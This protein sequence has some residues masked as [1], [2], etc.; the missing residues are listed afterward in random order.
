MT[1]WNRREAEKD[2][3][4]SRRGWVRLP[5]SAYGPHVAYVMVRLDG[6][7]GPVRILVTRESYDA[8]RARLRA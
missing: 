1:N 8:S 5:D 7:K 4:A 3:A 6:L 2:A